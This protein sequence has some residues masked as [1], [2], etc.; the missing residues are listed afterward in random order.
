M[1]FL[2]FRDFVQGGLQGSS[3]YQQAIN[4][5]RGLTQV[6]LKVNG[7][8]GDR[9]STT[10]QWLATRRKVRLAGGGAISTSVSVS[11]A[12]E[13]GG[14]EAARLC[15]RRRPRRCLLGPAAGSFVAVVEAKRPIVVGE[16][17]EQKRTTAKPDA[18]RLALIAKHRVKHCVTCH[19]GP[20][21]ARRFPPFMSLITCV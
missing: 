4:L 1:L 18:A 3:V 15:S 21:F 20:T 12:V 19:V 10:S 7:G 2:R 16:M 13:M 11:M 8:D 9:K 14:S 6:K 17:V 5:K